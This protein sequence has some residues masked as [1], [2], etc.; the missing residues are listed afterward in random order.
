MLSLTHK[1]KDERDRDIEF[2]IKT[3]ECVLTTL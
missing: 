2:V 1:K 3:F